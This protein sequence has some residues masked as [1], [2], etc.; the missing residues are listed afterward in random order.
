MMAASFVDDIEMISH[1][2]RDVKGHFGV[3]CYD[4]IP[5]FPV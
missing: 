4:I 2:K 3:V 1:G 5:P